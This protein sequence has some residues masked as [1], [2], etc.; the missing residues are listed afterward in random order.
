MY[1]LNILLTFLDDLDESWQFMLVSSLYSYNL[2]M[3]PSISCTSL[4]F[5]GLQRCLSRSRLTLVREVG[6]TVDSSL[7]LWSESWNFH[8]WL[9]SINQLSQIQLCVLSYCTWVSAHVTVWMLCACLW[10]CVWVWCL[11]AYVLEKNGFLCKHLHNKWTSQLNHPFSL[12]INDR[13]GGVD[14][15]ERLKAKGHRYT[16]SGKSIQPLSAVLN[17]KAPYV[18]II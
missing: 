13:T 7:D 1:P 18:N 14:G 5:K 3:H 17:F 15:S 12:D 2:F 16:P 10:V 11:C 6:Y 4:S 8:N 9:L